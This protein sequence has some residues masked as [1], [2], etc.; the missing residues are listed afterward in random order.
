MGQNLKVWREG[1]RKRLKQSLGGKCV[2][3]GKEE[4]EVAL[5]FSHII[6]L[7]DEQHVNR[8]KIG[9]THRLVQYRKEAKEGLLTLRCQSCNVKQSKEPKQG[10][11]TL[12]AQRA[13]ANNPF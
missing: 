1:A 8:V 5:I 3:C 4:P 11:L 13:S 2:D 10:F 6:P 12:T 7:S 9:A